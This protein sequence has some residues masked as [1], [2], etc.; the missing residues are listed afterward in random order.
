MAE[1]RFTWGARLNQAKQPN[2]E[3]I[4]HFNTMSY[5]VLFISSLQEME[6]DSVCVH[7]RCL[8]LKSIQPF[9]SSKLE[10]LIPQKPSSALAVAAVRAEPEDGEAMVR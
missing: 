2:N 10:R 6:D 1:R 7:W 3:T 8:I 4:D 9:L 5:T